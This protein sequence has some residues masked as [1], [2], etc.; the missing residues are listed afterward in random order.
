[1]DAI[2]AKVEEKVAAVSK[3]V[4]DKEVEATWG[5]AAE[6]AIDV[7]SAIKVVDVPEEEEVDQ[8]WW[9]WWFLFLEM[10]SFSVKTIYL[11][12]VN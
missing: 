11:S 9:R 5:V 4:T 6:G 10:S 1:M 3:G 7:E 12:S 2:I 8:P